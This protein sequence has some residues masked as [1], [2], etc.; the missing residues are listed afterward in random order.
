M[1]F[2]GLD[3]VPVLLPEEGPRQPSLSGCQEN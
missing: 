2:V 3:V 1:S